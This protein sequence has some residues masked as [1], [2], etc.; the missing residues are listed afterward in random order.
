MLAELTLRD[1][2]VIEEAHLDLAPGLSVITGET[3]AGKTMLLTA[4]GLLR[5]GKADPSLIRAGAPRGLV[6]G[7]VRLPPGHPALAE[8]QDSG[9]LVDD[10]DLMVG[11][12]IAESRSR[13][14]LGGA[15]V[16][17]GV[18]TRIVA[19]LVTVHGQADQLRLRTGAQQRDVVDAYAG[20]DHAAALATY[21]EVYERVGELRAHLERLRGQGAEAVREA[22]ALTQAVAEIERVA[23]Q[24]GEDAE[25]DARIER[26]THVEE[27]RVVAAQAHGALA[28]GDDAAAPPGAAVLV[29]SAR[30][31]LEAAAQRDGLIGELAARLREAEYQ[32]GDI[33]EELG[34]YLHEL[35]SDPATLEALHARRAQVRSLLRKY[36][37]SV[38]DV[39][40]WARFAA[41]RLTD[42]DAGDERIA[43]LSRQ[44]T[45]AMEELGAAAERVGAGRRAATKALAGAINGELAGLAMPGA[46]VD[47]EVAATDLGPH[48][49]DEVVF[50]LAAHPGA[51]ARPLG[52][53][54]SGGELS[55]VMLA[56][57]VALAAARGSTDETL[58]FDE[59]DAGIGGRAAIEVGR[60]LARVASHAQ[61][62]VVTHLAQVAAFADRHIVLDKRSDDAAASTL[63]SVASVSGADRE[64]ELARML[65]GQESSASAR[66]HARELL[67]LGRQGR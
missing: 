12:S 1:L 29:A 55:R 24:V 32:V 65:A 25:L 22:E 34:A 35:D 37:A 15:S 36:G 5:G 67:A 7:V 13:A 41:E 19:P 53:S 16:P 40:E 52:R 14:L 48:G 33:A 23:P 6:E 49:G 54:A 58:V 45:T 27:L 57:E 4:L 3:G 46:R 38:A 11:R 50:S 21:R 2:G 56:V 61:V 43:D 28:G 44:L 63:T 66:A 59:V 64:R 51:P 62:V 31:G 8:A 42:L 30:R 18:L 26:L 60:R 47:I 10:G 39:L 20:A 9:A 17:A